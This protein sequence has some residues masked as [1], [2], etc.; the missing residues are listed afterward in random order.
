MSKCLDAVAKVTDL[1]RAASQLLMAAALLA[2]V[3]K[4]TA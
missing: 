3:V 2:A 4:Y 1:V